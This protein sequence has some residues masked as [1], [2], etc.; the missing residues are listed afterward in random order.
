MSDKL[1]DYEGPFPCHVRFEGASVLDGI[2]AL[3]EEGCADP[4]LPPHLA[5]LNSSAQNYFL[6]REKKQTQG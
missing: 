5:E 1:V 3:V 6:I 2:R 4:P